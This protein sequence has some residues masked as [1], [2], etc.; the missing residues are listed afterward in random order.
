MS[1]RESQDQVHRWFDLLASWC[2]AS[3][4]S[5]ANGHATSMSLGNKHPK[6]KI[7]TTEALLE[8]KG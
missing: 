6:S 8:Q 3:L 2:R 4:G 1:Y 5:G 7:H